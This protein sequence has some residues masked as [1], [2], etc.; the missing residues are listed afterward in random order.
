MSQSS[1]AGWLVG[2]PAPT[3]R[4]RLYCF[5]YAGGSASIFHGWG[6]ALGPDV[7]VCAV[8]LPGR[9]ARLAEPPVTTMQA[10]LQ[11]LVPVIARHNDRPFA[12]FG[13][14]V[15]ALVAFELTRYLRLHGMSLPRQLIVSGCQAPQ[16]RSVPRNYHLLDDD[17]FIDV[18]GVYKGT[19]RMVLENRELMDLLMPALRADFSIAE[20]YRYRG[21]PQLGLPI[22]LFAGEHDDIRGEGQVDGWGRESSHP[23][24]TIWFDGG[25]FFIDT[26]RQQVVD[27]VR[28][29]LSNVHEP[30]HA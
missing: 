21:G 18:L 28:A 17:A 25:H 1:Q 7:E 11:S 29:A 9:G 8:Q 5:S 26:H 6:S 10:L 16:F 2:Q 23:L 19:P 3:A 20:T 15:G 12:F 24:S 14:S 13:H 30:L 22:T 27:Q 4:L